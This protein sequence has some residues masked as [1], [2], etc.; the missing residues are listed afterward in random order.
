MAPTTKNLG[1]ALALNFGPHPKGVFCWCD[2][3]GMRNGMN[4]EKNPWRR[5]VPALAIG[6]SAPLML[7]VPVP[8]AC[9]SRVEQTGGSE[10]LPVVPLS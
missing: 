1:L 7:N 10:A 3:S 6:M 2:R 4:P 5:I 9:E 8:G